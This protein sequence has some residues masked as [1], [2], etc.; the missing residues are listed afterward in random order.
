MSKIQFFSLLNLIITITSNSVSISLNKKIENNFFTIPISIGIPNNIQIFEVQV[1]TTTSETWVPSINT[2]Y[3]ISPKY[4]MSLSSTSNTTDKIMEIFDE[5]GDVTGNATH[6]VIKIGQYTLEEFGFVSVVNY[7]K[8]FKDYPNG[9][10]GLGYKQDHGDEFNFIRMLKQKGLVDNEIFTIDPFEK[11]LIIGNYPMKYLNNIYSFCNLTETHDLDDDYRAGWVCELTHTFFF[12]PKKYLE[13]GVE[14]TNARVIF[15]SAYQYIGIPKDNNLKLFKDHYFENILNESCIEMR[16][17]RETYFICE[18][19]DKLND[20]NITFIIGGFGYVLTKNE[21]FKPLYGNKLECV[22]RFVKQNDNIFSFGV[23][24]VKNYIMAYDAEKQQVGF[25]GGNKI[26]YFDDWKLWMKGISPKQRD[27]M[28]KLIIGAS[29]LGGILFLIV[30][31]LIIRACRR[32]NSS[33]IE[34]GP[35][36]ND[37]QGPNVNF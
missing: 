30:F 19:D 26:D 8:N 15:D 2:T 34:H 12:K 10:L 3:K 21:L 16:A 5:D 4:D 20:A 1:D 27:Y 31:C 29:V 23:P 36:M 28:N 14:T 32:K 35:L 25:L 13:D 24:F 6:D 18:N 7:P 22:L 37:E 11:E 9:K 17:K 33:D